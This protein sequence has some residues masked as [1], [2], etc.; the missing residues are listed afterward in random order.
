ML[1]KK[2]RII[3]TELFAI[4]RNDEIGDLS[5]AF[6]L[7]IKNINDRIHYIESF[8]S[9]VAHEFKNP[10]AAIKS[11]IELIDN[12]NISE[13]DRKELMDNAFAEI[14]HLELLLNSIRN[15]YCTLFST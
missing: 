3:T 13:N 15:I 11:S 1:D 5:R 4:K 12:P 2:G 10:L 7:L 9:D 6:S 8:S 14:H